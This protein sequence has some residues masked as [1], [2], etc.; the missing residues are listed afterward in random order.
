[1]HA[2][3]A[4]FVGNIDEFL[5]AL[6]SALFWAPILVSRSSCVLFQRRDLCRGAPN[7]GRLWRLI[8]GSLLE[9]ISKSQGCVRAPWELHVALRELAEH[10]PPRISLQ[11]LCMH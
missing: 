3:F 1:M 5:E 7:R 10:Q 9:R 8:L 4:N 6:F 11:A 2:C